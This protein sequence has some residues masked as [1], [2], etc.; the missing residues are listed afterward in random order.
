MVLHSTANL[1]SFKGVEGNTIRIMPRQKIHWPSVR[2]WLL[3][4]EKS[5]GCDRALFLESKFP[6]V[7]ERIFIGVKHERLVNCSHNCRYIALSYVWGGIPQLLLTKSNKAVLFQD[8]A[9]REFEK[10]IPQVIKDAMLFVHSI[11]EEMLWVDSLCIVQDDESVKHDLI[12]DMASI[13]SGALATIITASGENAGFGLPGVRENSRVLEHLVEIPDFY[14]GEVFT[15]QTRNSFLSVRSISILKI[16][17][18]SKRTPTHMPMNHPVI[19]SIR[20][21]CILVIRREM[22]K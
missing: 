14:H 3:S 6:R 4:C 5:H 1:K 18:E 10:D 17:L 2:L 15:L 9:L 16:G 11:G 19:S 21:F 12:S 8:G 7:I 22:K 20:C 13:Y